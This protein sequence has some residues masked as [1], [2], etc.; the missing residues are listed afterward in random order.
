V[1]DTKDR[2]LW[3]LRRLNLF[4]GMSPS[5]VESVAG[6]L[7]DRA[8]RRRETILA[9]ESPG[10][11][12]H[13]VKS[14]LVRIYSLSP[15]G[16]EL[17]TAILR[18]GQ[19]FGT[20]ALVGVGERA[21]F[22]E[23]FEDSYVCEATAEEFLRIMSSHPGLAAKVMVAMARQALRL[24]QQLERLAFQEVPARLAEVLL[25]LAEA[26]GGQLPPHL[27]HEELAKL[28][29]TTRETV[30]KALAQFAARGLVEVG[31]RR[32]AIRDAEG[33]RGTLGVEEART[34]G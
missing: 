33:L 23:A 26:N 20:S 13:L 2:K 14:G 6:H 18:P 5:E 9:P 28:V 29:G 25:Q 27:T 30:T 3:Y 21:A 22:A 19:L 24:E 7:R 12:I 16:K 31:Y 10:D 8:C 32:I 17:T 34:R 4:A 1:A 11:R 15:E